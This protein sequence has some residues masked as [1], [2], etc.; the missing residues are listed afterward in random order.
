[1]QDNVHTVNPFVFVMEQTPC[2]LSDKTK[3]DKP[4]YLP[5]S[6][7]RFGTTILPLFDSSGNIKWSLSICQFFHALLSS[8]LLFVGFC[9]KVLIPLCLKMSF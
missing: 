1:M 7:C 8:S 2:S 4:L 9:N 6:S 5:A 3:R